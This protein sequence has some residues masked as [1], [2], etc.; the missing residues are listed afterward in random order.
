MIIA[1]FEFIALIILGGITYG[2]LKSHA[3]DYFNS[4]IALNPTAFDSQ[5][6]S[7][8]KSIINYFLF[9]AIIGGA[10]GLWAWTQ[11]TK[12]EGIY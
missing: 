1:I 6:V 7:I 9:F 4:Q 3:L 10:I 8:T 11:R 2:I 5:V 12:P